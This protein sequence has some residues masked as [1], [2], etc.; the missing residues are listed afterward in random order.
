MEGNRGIEEVQEFMALL[1]VIV[2]HNS[3]MGRIELESQQKGGLVKIADIPEQYG[4]AVRAGQE[5]VLPELRAEFKSLYQVQ[6]KSEGLLN[7]VQKCLE[8]E[9]GTQ[10]IGAAV[11]C[12]CALTY[13]GPMSIRDPS[14]GYRLLQNC[15]TWIQPSLCCLFANTLSDFARPGGDLDYLTEEESSHL[16]PLAATSPQETQRYIRGALANVAARNELFDFVLQSG[17]LRVYRRIE[18]RGHFCED[19]LVIIE[20]VRILANLV[21]RSGTH[22]EVCTEHVIAFLRDVLH[23]CVTLLKGDLGNARAMPPEEEFITA[24]FSPDDEP[25]LGIRL[26]WEQPPKIVEIIPDKPA[27]FLEEPLEVDDQLIEVNGVDVQEMIQEEIQHMFEARPLRLVFRRLIKADA[28]AEEDSEEEPVVQQIHSVTEYGDRDL[29]LE[30]FHLAILTLHNLA[31]VKTNH[32]KMLAEPRIL[33]TLLELIPSEVLPHTAPLGLLALDM[34]MPA[35]G[36]F[37]P[38][39]HCDVGVLHGSGCS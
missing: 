36:N 37:W 34:L 25:P 21:S 20:S 28:A 17:V 32:Q 6:A 1:R 14:M 11:E 3:F 26:K 35:K 18:T 9:C 30:C 27:A 2:V 31:A 10:L 23:H 15:P 8:M 39:L 12:L 7:V 4:R 29:Y 24:T 33:N 5:L 13:L 22:K 19:F 38:Y 16:Y